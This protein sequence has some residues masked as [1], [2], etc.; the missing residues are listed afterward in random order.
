MRTK[1]TIA[2]AAALLAASG[3]G[4]AKLPPLSPEARAKADE[5]K[6]RRQGIGVSVVHGTERSSGILPQATEGEGC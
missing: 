5:T 1:L 3:A 2:I 4:W 6:A